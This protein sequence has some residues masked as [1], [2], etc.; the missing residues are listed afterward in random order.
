MKL[1]LAVLYALSGTAL[2]QQDPAPLQQNNGKLNVAS[3]KAYDPKG[4][5]CFMAPRTEP[6][7]RFSIS[8]TTAKFLVQLAYGLQNWEIPPMPDWASTSFYSVQAL[9]ESSGRMDEASLQAGLQQLLAERFGLKAHREQR[10]LKIF[11]LIPDSKGVRFKP[12]GT[13]KPPRTPMGGGGFLTGTMTMGYA[14]HAL[15]MQADR[16]V[17]DRTG[18]TGDFD[19]D[20]TWTP[21]AFRTG[22]GP[23]GATLP[24]PPGVGP[25]PGT[26]VK[27]PA[28]AMNPDG[29]GLNTALREQLGLRLDGRAEPFPVLVVDSIHRPSEN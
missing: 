12:H 14:A 27:G 26:N 22:A 2:A 7:G 3:V 17:I 29:P 1:M 23:G 8:C 24:P 28:R 10:Q 9:F 6:N 11:A 25:P 20:L 16:P 13:A 19:I 5:G 21:D 15:S 4:M 18:L